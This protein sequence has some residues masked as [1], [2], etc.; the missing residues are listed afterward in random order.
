[1]RKLLALALLLVSSTA[2]HGQEPAAQERADAPAATESAVTP[3]SQLPE[4]PAPV[5]TPKVDMLGHTA[6]ASRDIAPLRAPADFDQPAAQ[7]ITAPQNFW[8]LVGAIVLG[9]IILAVLL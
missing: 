6:N 4:E 3:A 5:T 1:M 9:G 2:V 8:W 7:D